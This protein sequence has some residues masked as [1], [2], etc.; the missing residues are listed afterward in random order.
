MLS[1][2]WHGHVP[3][4]PLNGLPIMPA[5]PF[6]AL[7]TMAGLVAGF[8]VAAITLRLPAALKREWR[9]DALDF[10]EMP[11]EPA[12]A[13][14]VSLG[15]CVGSWARLAAICGACASIGWLALWLHGP[16]LQAVLYSLVFWLLVS[17]AVIDIETLYIP[18]VIVLPLLWAGMLYFAALAPDQLPGSVMG[19]AI[20]YCALRWLPVGRGDAKLCAV[21][22]AWLGAGSML[23]FGLIASVLGVIV[24]GAY[25]LARGRAEP[26]PYGPSLV[27][28]FIAT[29]VMATNHL[30]MF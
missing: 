23:T 12:P 17:A 5:W 26:C 16:G 14:D 29:H 24:G 7:S 11:P 10:L 1:T 30:A 19:A 2:P 4:L 28:G 27:A 9:A 20:G 22:G 15:W 21:A 13:R 6:F 18:D 25:Y 3:S 8:V